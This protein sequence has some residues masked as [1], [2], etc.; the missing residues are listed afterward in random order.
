[1]VRSVYDLAL[2]LKDFGDELMARDGQGFTLEPITT[3]FFPPY[4]STG[5]FRAD[6]YLN[7]EGLVEELMNLNHMLN[8]IR[9]CQMEI[10]AL[11]HR[12]ICLGRVL[13]VKVERLQ[14]HSLRRVN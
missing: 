7:M 4:L 5:V 2:Q 9:Q 6:L 10:I 3:P 12:L 8:Q 14:Q 11:L 1:M 13:Q